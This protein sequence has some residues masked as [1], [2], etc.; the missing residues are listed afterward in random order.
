MPTSVSHPAA[1]ECSGVVARRTREVR[2][3]HERELHGRLA[4]A[5]EVGGVEAEPDV[6]HLAR[7]RGLVLG[8]PYVRSHENRAE[9]GD[10]GEVARADPAGARVEE[11]GDDRAGGRDRNTSP[12]EHIG[13]ARQERHRSEDQG[14][15]GEHARSD[16]CRKARTRLHGRNGM[17]WDVPLTCR[18]RGHIDPYSGSGAEKLARALL[19]E[20]SQLGPE[21][22]DLALE[23]LETLFDAV[24]AA[25]DGAATGVV[26]CSSPSGGSPPPSRCL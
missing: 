21:L 3:G 17:D 22:R 16:A 23:P 5:E 25:R 4:R 26:G 15:A 9:R 2:A 7:Q 1:T 8:A 14:L 10:G 18:G 24:V 20:R 12:A 6:E 13:V 11:D 19:A